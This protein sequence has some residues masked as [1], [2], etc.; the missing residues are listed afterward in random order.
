MPRA[1]EFEVSSRLAAP[2][3]EVW[4]RISTMEGVNDELSPLIRMTHPP[5]VADL[6]PGNVPL[7]ERLFRSWILLFGVL[8]FDYDDLVLVRVDPERGFLERSTMLSQRSWEH[9]RTIEDAPG[10]SLITD[11]IRFVPRLAPLGPAL[12]PVLR[13]FFRHRHRRLHR[14]FG[15][16]PVTR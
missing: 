12:R 6:N 13:G 8:P 7:G 10:G 4:D 14:R 9:E 2:R 5:D 1:R 15:G 16:E 11:R 3:R